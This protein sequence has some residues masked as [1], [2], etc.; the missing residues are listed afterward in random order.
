MK[1]WQC[2]VCGYIFEGNEPP[3]RCPMCGAPKEK[4]V[5]LPDEDNKSAED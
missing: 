3:D 4:F 2:S 5:L 1:K